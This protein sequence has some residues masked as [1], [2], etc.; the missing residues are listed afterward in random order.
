MPFLMVVAVL[1][2]LT[3]VTQA[4]AL[5][6]EVQTRQGVPTLLI[7]GQP[8]PPMMLFHMGGGGP[9][10][11]ICKLTP[12]W[13]QFSY[14][15][16][17]PADDDNVAAHWR[18]IMPVGD[19]FVDDVRLTEGTLD[20]PESANLF[21]G[22]EFEG[23]EPPKDFNYFLNSS[24]GAAVDWSL[25]ADNPRQGQKCLRVRITSPG[26]INYHI[27][28]YHKFA[29]KRGTVY[30]VSAWMRSNEPREVEMNALHQGP[31]WTTYGGGTGKSDELLRLGAARG[32][33]MGNPP[34]PVVWTE[35]GKEPD[36][37]HLDAM[38][39]HILSVD[40]Q[41]LIIPRL[42]LDAPQWWKQAHPEHIQVYDVGRQVMAS[43]ASELWQKDAAAALR[44]TVRHLEDKFGD[45]MLGYHPCAQSAGEWFYD[46]VW[47]KIM[48]NF[49]EPFRAAFARWAAAKYGTV[50][51]L[52]KA[53]GQPEVTFAT[54]RV[55]SMDERLEGKVGVFRDPTSQRFVI[56]F[57]EYMQV[58]LSDYLMHCARIV[59]EET[60]RQK[61]SVFFYG[62]HYELSGFTYGAQVTGHFR[63][64]EVLHCPDVDVLVSPISYGDRRSG[65]AGS[66]MSPVDSIQLHGKLWLNED[67]TRTHLSSTDSGY[68]RTDTMAETLGVYRRNFGHQFER[69][70]GTWWMDFGLGWMADKEVFD[71]FARERDLWQQT[72]STGA[73]SPQV[74]MI[75]DEASNFYLRSSSEI[76]AFTVSQMRRRFNAM[77]CPVGL[78]LL[79]DLCEGKLP[80]SVR[81]YV[82]LNDFRLTDQQRPQIRA[83]VA[84]QGKVAL[85]LYAPGYV[86]DRPSADNIAETIGFRV[87]QWDEPG[88]TKIALAD[89]LPAWLQ[90]VPAGQIIGDDRKPSPRFTV[91][92]QPG[93]T[94]LGSYEGTSNVGLASRQT[95]AW[96]SIFCAALEVS[97]EVLRAAAR[98]AGAHV[99]CD[100]NDIIST[101]P[102]FVSIHAASPGEKTLRLPKKVVVT[103]LV[104]GEKMGGP[105]DCLVLQMAKGET[106]LF[107]W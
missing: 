64:H 16:R 83:Q 46:R 11:L 99:Y 100:T 26:T 40:P 71:N 67:D 98:L 43:P 52:R 50:E 57:A 28:F 102:G 81:L 41:A 105:T 59:K 33:H 72:P 55:P 13:Q 51:A 93:V 9:T 17:A 76:T 4:Q 47:E 29:I 89:E 21:E 61:L 106:R 25:V 10:P 92:P 77:G 19:W 5:Q 36:F 14:T 62:Y 95:A 54:I 96:T 39:Q 104:T 18:N 101:C 69:R 58:C 90:G 37:N 84:N 68:G 74:A 38:V 35:P 88:S 23:Q 30:T 85:W 94:P 27:H 82:F 45:H 78:Y 63:L 7:D 103:D 91:P 34:L 48:P 56:D 53:W 24:T 20:K 32:L 2:G 49:E 1:I 12:Q 8:V 73:F 79:D 22:G 75:T 42:N 15:F 31:P 107:G 80:S 6:A 60:N 65:G 44:Q 86:S 66:F 3:C 97:P 70:C 87:A